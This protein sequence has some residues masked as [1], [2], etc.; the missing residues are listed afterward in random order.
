MDNFELSEKNSSSKDMMGHWFGGFIVGASNPKAIVFFTA[1]FPQFINTQSS[2]LAQYLIL[3]STFAV[4]ELFWLSFY[5]AIARRS[6]NWLT[7]P[8]RAKRFNQI[9]GGVFI[10]AGLLLSSTSRATTN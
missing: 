9:T 10:G 5:A 6:S 1:L 4:M 2:L 7:K 3:A 8:G